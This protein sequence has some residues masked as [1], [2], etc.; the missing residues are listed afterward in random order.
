[1]PYQIIAAYIGED[2]AHVPLFP[3]EIRQASSILQLL[4]KSKILCPTKS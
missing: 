3:W 2:K 4:N 1:M